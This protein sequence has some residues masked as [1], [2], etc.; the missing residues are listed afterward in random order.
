MVL[1][2][3]LHFS[4]QLVL[5]EYI[6][7]TKK[8]KQENCQFNNHCVHRLH[9]FATGAFRQPVSKCHAKCH[10]SCE[11]SSSLFWWQ[12]TQVRNAL[13]LYR[14]IKPCLLRGRNITY[15]VFNLHLF[16]AFSVRTMLFLFINKYLKHL[17]YKVATSASANK[18]TFA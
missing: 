16:G 4:S 12:W 9:G 15:S 6:S 3:C 13:R 14:S 2:I 8:K 1:I 10:I 11:I 7:V 5:T 17:S 18:H